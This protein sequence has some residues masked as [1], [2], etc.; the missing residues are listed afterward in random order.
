MIQSFSRVRA[1]PATRG[2]LLLPDP[3][4]GASPETHWTITM[5]RVSVPETCGGVL[6]P[7]SAQWPQPRAEWVRRCLISEQPDR[8]WTAAQLKLTIDHWFPQSQHDTW[9]LSPEERSRVHPAHWFCQ[10]SQGARIANPKRSALGEYFTPSG[11]A[12]LV[13]A[14]KISGRIGGSLGGPAKA[15]YAR[16]PEGRAAKV[17]AGKISALTASS[18]N[19]DWSRTAAGRLQK[20]LAAQVSNCIR[21]NIN[22][23]KPCTCGYHNV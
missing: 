10:N 21:W 19:T 2:K 1:L 15:A 14:G 3:A 17:R 11:L 16:T 5:R 23:S 20:S 18:R 12:S 6:V 9:N 8:A 7:G 22:R 4:G 13:V